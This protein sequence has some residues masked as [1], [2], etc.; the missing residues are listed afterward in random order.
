MIRKPVKDG[1]GHSVWDITWNPAENKIEYTDELVHESLLFVV[2][3]KE[4]KVGSLEHKLKFPE[5]YVSTYTSS[6][7]QAAFPIPGTAPTEKA[8]AKKIIIDK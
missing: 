6:L 3:P 4:K 7:E 2:K 8:A 5:R 1:L